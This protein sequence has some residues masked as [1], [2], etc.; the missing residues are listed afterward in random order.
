MFTEPLLRNGLHS[1]LFYCSMRVC[2]GRYQ[3]KTAVYRVTA[4]Q[5]VFTPQYHSNELL[6][7]EGKHIRLFILH[8]P[9]NII[10]N[11]GLVKRV[12]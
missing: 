11:F 5:R 6:N 12:S 4:K 2:F 9:T 8:N 1:P 10:I 3:A 7:L